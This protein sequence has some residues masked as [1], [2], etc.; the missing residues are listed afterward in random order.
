VDNNKTIIV[1]PITNKSKLKHKKIIKLSKRLNKKLYEF[2]VTNIVISELLN[3]IEP[4][5]NYL[6]SKNINIISGNRL[7]NYLMYDVI[8]YI[9]EKRKK[10]ILDLEISILVNN[11]IDQS[12]D[13]IK[14]ISKEA[15]LVNIVT[16]HIDKFKKLETYLY[17]ELGIMIKISN[18][19]RKSLSKSDIIINIDFPN[20]L[21]NKY[22]I[23][24]NCVIVNINET[25]TIKAKKFNGINVNDYK[26][27]VPEK[28]KIEKFSNKVIYE[29]MLYMRRR[30]F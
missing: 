26:I 22:T 21:I 28:Y 16:N 18:N 6:Y 13:N 17:E 7:F 4:L 29:S 3:E 25:I 27:L 14:L 8:N 10:D 2:D 23:S 30:K 12:L 1:L 11:N 5:K 9:G 24:D 20:E 19:K 15:K